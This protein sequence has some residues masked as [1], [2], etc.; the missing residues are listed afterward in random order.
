M[1]T[2]CSEPKPESEQRRGNEPKIISLEEPEEEP[3]IKL[4]VLVK[5]VRRHHKPNQIIGYVESIVMTKIKLKSDTCLLCEFEP[6]SIK[7]A[8]DNEDWLHAMN[9]DW[10]GQYLKLSAKT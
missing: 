1:N 6:Q 10:E 2:E 8:S 9:E 7:Y 3:R 4:P 5:Y